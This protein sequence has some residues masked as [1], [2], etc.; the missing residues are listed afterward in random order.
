MEMNVPSRN[1]S[2]SEALSLG[3]EFGSEH[4]FSLSLG[5]EKKLVMSS[6]I[7]YAF[8]TRKRH[9]SDVFKVCDLCLVSPLSLRWCYVLTQMSLCT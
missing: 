9:S 2:T 8:N 7:T 6:G 5:S 3:S 1:D 4:H